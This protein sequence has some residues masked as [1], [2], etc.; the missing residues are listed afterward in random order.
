M[1]QFIQQEA[2]IILNSNFPPMSFY[3]FIANDYLTPPFFLLKNKH[4]TLPSI[5]K[6]TNKQTLFCMAPWSISLLGEMLPD[7]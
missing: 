7:S 4:P 3:L 6:Q 5:K 2:I 1:L